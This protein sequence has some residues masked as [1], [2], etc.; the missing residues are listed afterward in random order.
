MSNFIFCIPNPDD[1]Q[2]PTCYE[3]PVLVNPWWRWEHPNWLKRIAD[4][5][6]DPIPWDQIIAE[7]QEW[8]K[9]LVKLQHLD[10][11][12]GSMNDDN[13]RSK[14]RDTIRSAAKAIVTANVP[15]AEFRVDNNPMSR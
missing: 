4:G 6:G 13:L 3:I 11:V 1:P 14:L 8:A 10:S 7:M 5:K 2:R 12:I 15:N 9:D